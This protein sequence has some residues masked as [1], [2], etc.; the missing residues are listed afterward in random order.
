LTYEFFLYLWK[1]ARCSVFL[2]LPLCN[3]IG[4]VL[5]MWIFSK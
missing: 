2:L 1:I 3:Y 4:I 5:K